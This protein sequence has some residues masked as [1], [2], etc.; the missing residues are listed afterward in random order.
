M[1]T[2]FSK[3][4]FFWIIFS[5]VSLFP[6]EIPFSQF[7]D[8]E[9]APGGRSTGLGLADI[10]GDGWKDIIVADGNDMARQHL[11]VYYNQGDGTFPADPDWQSDDIDYHGHLAVGDVNKDGWP[12]VAVSVY[13]GPGG[14]SNPGK[15]KV[16]YNQGGELEKTPSFESYEFYTFSCA[17]GDADG[18]GD[19]DLATTGG[20]PY[21][22]LYDQG[23]IFINNNGTFSTNPEWTSDFTFG[24]LDVDFGDMD[25]NGFLDV[26]F[27]SED[28]P[29]YI[30]LASD[31]GIIADTAGWYSTDPDNYINSLDIGFTGADQV[32]S[33]VMTGNNQ[34]GGD[35]EVRKYSFPDGVP[36]SSGADWSSDPFG[37]GSGIL[38]ADV[39]EDDIPDLIYGGWW[40][41]VKIALGDEDG[42]FEINPSYTSSTSSV[43]EAIQMAD[44]DRDDIM[45]KTETFYWD[46]TKGPVIYLEKQLVENI[47]SVKINGETVNDTSY[48]YVPNKN[49]VSLGSNLSPGDT[50]E[51][52]YEFS[53]D[54]DMVISNWD[55]GKGNYIF[56]NTLITGIN[57]PKEKNDEEISLRISPNPVKENLNIS[58]R[59]NEKKEITVQ[60]FDAFG[61]LI[62]TWSLG[63]ETPGDHSVSKNISKESPGIYVVVFR[64]GDSVMSRKIIVQ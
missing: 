41:P 51:V 63:V 16:Y 22:G 24:S 8:W 54:C 48:C 25:Q 52:N 57:T 19:L 56:Y 53:N 46:G 20:E 38:L 9:S 33:A 5:S 58:Y 45:E 6:Q 18:D 31:E 17:F 47:L 2:L 36:D 30:F 60:L 15:V 34:L 10:N 43:V 26:V 35:G 59:I 61:Q 7:P 29:N 23:K 37:Y 49:W 32:M 12:D 3:V 42:D 64:A 21:S 13:I 40:L 39:N 62:S 28:T 4:F 11:V 44:L 50:I 27:S 14:F 55:S 1:H